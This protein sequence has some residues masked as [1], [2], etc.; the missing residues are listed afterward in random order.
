MS[1]VLTRGTVVIDVE[2]CK[3]ALARHG[4]T[5]RMDAVYEAEQSTLPPKP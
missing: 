4:V 3:G 1:A 2:A 5:P